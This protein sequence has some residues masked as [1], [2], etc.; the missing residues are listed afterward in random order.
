MEPQTFNHLEELCEELCEAIVDADLDIVRRILA[1]SPEIVNQKYLTHTPLHTAVYECEDDYIAQLMLDIPCVDLTI[2]D[3]DGDTAF[4][5][6]VAQGKRDVVRRMINMNPEVLRIFDI[7]GDTPIHVAHCDT[8]MLATIIETGGRHATKLLG[9]RG[10]PV[11][12]GE[13]LLHRYKDE[14]VVRLRQKKPLTVLEMAKI[15]GNT[16]A[17]NYLQNLICY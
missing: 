13:C 15:C 2:Q 8:E 7:Y 16:S 6:A 14:R 12:E 11:G 3:S 1:E 5:L 9:R 17:V 10:N 4:N